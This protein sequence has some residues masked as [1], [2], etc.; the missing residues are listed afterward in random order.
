MDQ[1]H[2]VHTDGHLVGGDLD[3]VLLGQTG[4]V[5]GQAVV[6]ESVRAVQVLPQHPKH[7]RRNARLD[8]ANQ[9]E[10]GAKEV[11]ISSC[12]AGIVKI[13]SWGN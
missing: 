1:W 13:S 3:F 10:E 2:E 8:S 11:W 12:V 4:R 5:G 7:G 6:R 9:S